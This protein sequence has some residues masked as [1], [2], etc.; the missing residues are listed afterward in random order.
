MPSISIR[1]G[2]AAVAVA[3][4]TLAGGS[5]LVS[6]PAHA[7]SWTCSANWDTRSFELPNKP[8]VRAEAR[9]CVYKDGNTRRGRIEIRWNTNPGA[10][11]GN[12]FDKFVV[13]AR[14]E[15]DDRVIAS[16]SC[17]LTDE[18]NSD[19]HGSDTCTTSYVTSSA[20]EGWTGDGKV[21]YNIDDDGKSDFTWNLH[22]SGEVRVQ[23]DGT[24]VGDEPEQEPAPDPEDTPEPAA[25]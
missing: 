10:W 17:D 3:T 22:G 7:A 23:P 5:V 24:E 4:A 9:S 6:S 15:R 11:I 1:S 21:T 20:Q 13:Q 25:R 16:Q 8:N 18:I 14:L 2:I 19:V 12:R